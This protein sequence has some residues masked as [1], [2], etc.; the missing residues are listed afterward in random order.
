MLTTCSEPGCE[1]LVMGGRCLEHDQ[2]PARV[3]VRGRPLVAAPR[4]V[5]GYGHGVA[6]LAAAGTAR[7]IDARRGAHAGLERSRN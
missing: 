6:T 4:R 5:R 2:R 3:F 7:T 1:T